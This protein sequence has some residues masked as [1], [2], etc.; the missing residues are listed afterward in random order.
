MTGIAS[1]MQKGGY[2]THIVGKWDCGMATFDHTPRGRGYNTSLIYFEHKNDYW[3][4]VQ[5]QSGCLK[6]TPGIVDLWKDDKPAYGMNGTK[7][8]EYLFADEIYGLINNFSKTANDEPFFMVY[9][10]H[11]A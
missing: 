4:Q 6:T 3:T 2:Q 8:E 9:T 5:M 11:T 1:K 10:P 7:Y